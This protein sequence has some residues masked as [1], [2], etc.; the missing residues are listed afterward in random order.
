MRHGGGSRPRD[1]RMLGHMAKAMDRSNESVLHRLRP[2]NGNERINSH[3]RGPPT[4]PRQQ[5]V[6]RGSSRFQ[7]GRPS[8]A[9]GTM[10]APGIAGAN[11]MNMSPQQQLELYAMLEQQSRLMA[12]MLGPQQM[13]MG[14]EGTGQIAGS[15]PPQRGRSLFDRVQAHPRRT[16]NNTYKKDPQNS[17][18]GGDQQHQV[19]LAD[20]TSHMDVEMSQANTDITSPDGVCPFRL[21]C[22]KKDCP[23]AHQ[24]PAAPP[25]TTI[26]VTDVCSFGAACKNHKCTGRHPSPAQKIAHQT[27]TDCKY[28]PNCSNGSDCP[29]RHPSVPPCRNGAD[30]T[31]PNCKFTHSKVLCRFNPCTGAS[32]TFKHVDGQK[33]GKFE[34]KIW[35]ADGVKQHV[36]ERKFVTDDGVEEELIRPTAQES[37]LGTDPVTQATLVT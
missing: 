11:V 26:D 17:R 21:S 22:Y 29:F 15:L 2:Q 32:C 4:G 3:S 36:S 10:Q 6:G 7:N 33:R 13:G 27:E 1:K 37:G 28:Y 12:Q 8:G 20:P 14:S 9:L 19:H 30:C 18:Y 5:S 34:D 31:T 25:G 23:L 24:S 35:V 16:Q